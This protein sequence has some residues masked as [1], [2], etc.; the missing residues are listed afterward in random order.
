M[1]EILPAKQINDKRYNRTDKQASGQGKV[2]SEALALNGYINGE[3]AEPGDLA[4][5]R[6]NYTY[7]HQQEPD[8]DENSTEINHD[9]SLRNSPS[10]A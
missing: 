5:E 6:K 4:G 3:A 7:D 10:D 1:R 9:Q 2:Q 8:E